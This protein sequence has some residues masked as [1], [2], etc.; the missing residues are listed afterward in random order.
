MGE[1][2]ELIVDAS[3]LNKSKS[4]AFTNVVITVDEK[5]VAF[6]SHT[7]YLAMNK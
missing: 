2:D 7:K 3:C 1:G 4:I 6:G 5:V